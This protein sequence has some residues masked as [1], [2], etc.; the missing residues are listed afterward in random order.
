M[1]YPLAYGYSLVGRVTRCGESVEDAEDII[2]KLVFTFSPHSSRVI[3]DRDRVHLVPDGISA[4]DAM[5][6]P[7]VETAVSIVHDAHVRIGERIA[8]FGQGLIGLLVTAVLC[9]CHS[10]IGMGQ[11]QHCRISSFDT[12]ID[13]LAASSALGSSE[14]LLPR[15]A[16]IAGPF[17]VAIEVSGQGCGLQSAIDNTPKG[18]R[19]IIAS[20]YGKGDVNLKLGIDFHRSRKTIVTS[21]VSE[22]PPDLRCLWTKKRRFNLTWELVR[23]IRPSKILTETVHLERAQ[24]AYERLHCGKDIAISFSYDDL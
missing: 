4:K 16:K 11:N 5:F 12:V 21:Q 19:I 7:S 6:M 1:A 24:E 14:A 13:R 10:G 15:D 23:M 17:D 18:G 9:G 2:G 8:I 22:I 3:V 20:W